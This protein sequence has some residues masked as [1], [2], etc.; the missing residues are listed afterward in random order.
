MRRWGLGGA[1]RAALY[2]AAVLSIVPV[3]PQPGA[4]PPAH[5]LTIPAN[6]WVKQPP[7]SQTL[8][9]GRF[10]IFQGRGWN[11]MRYD[12]VSGRM[13]LYDG[14]AEP[15]VYVFESIYANA[16][17][18]YDVVANRLSLEKVSNWTRRNGEMSPLPANSTDPTPYDRHFYSCFIYSASKNRVYLWSG[19]NNTIQ[20]NE[21]GDT[22][23]YDFRTRAWREISTPRPYNV[24]EQAC[25]YDPYLEK[26]V[27]FGGADRTYG[28]GSHTY[29]FDLNTELWT[30]ARPPRSPT[31]RSGQTM[32]FDPVR[33]VTWMFGGALFGR[34]GNELWS[35]DAAGNTWTQVP[36]SG[37]WPAQR[38]FAAMAYDS[39]RDVFL[40]WGGV[41]ASD[42]PFNDTWLFHPSTQRWE[43]LRPSASPDGNLRYYSEDLEY[44]P[45]ND[46]F[47]L[48]LGGV[49]WL[50]R[51]SGA[52]GTVIENEPAAVP[53]MRIV[54]ANP[55]SSGPTID[56]TLPRD[57]DVRVMVFDARGRRVQTLA[58]GRYSAGI[59]SVSWSGRVGGARAPSG[60][61]VVRLVTAGRTVAKRFALVR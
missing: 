53:A 27:L 50:Y 2:A 6:T 16:L 61:Y 17:W 36:P 39:R 52:P 29:L 12:A 60:V 5:A 1:V 51:A 22:W 44:D 35:Y 59:H 31:P 13:W 57:A 24:Y 43:Q 26:M 56:F 7:P 8:P 54:T 37:A 3:S 46:V 19:A 23:A 28:D 18:S 41:T 15:P 45:V 10:G 20:G 32:S 42:N 25:S 30:D 34:A 49:F 11:H 9:A 33:R 4:L 55:S 21:F 58:T 38:R 47:V 40:L 48:N 14:Y